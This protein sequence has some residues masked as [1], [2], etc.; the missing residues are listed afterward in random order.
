MYQARRSL[1]LR[2]T[3]DDCQASSWGAPEHMFHPAGSAYL[4]A[5]SA[6]ELGRPVE[7]RSGREPV[8]GY[9][10]ISPDLGGFLAGFI[11]GEGSFRIRKQPKNTNHGCNMTLTARDDDADLIYEL[12]RLTELGRVTWSP[13][14]G[15]SRPQVAWNLSAKADCIRLIEILDEYPLRGRKSRDYA[16][17][18]AAVHWWTMGDPT[19]TAR[20]RDWEPMIYLKKRLQDAKQF[21]PAEALRD[22]DDHVPGLDQAGGAISR[23]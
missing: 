4:L 15:R 10:S 3:H 11:E 8:G 13:A 20:F 23:A 9:P 14:R 19:R 2:H 7:S 16:I 18:S 21:S 17:W 6:R 12:A 1:S 5:M 22:I